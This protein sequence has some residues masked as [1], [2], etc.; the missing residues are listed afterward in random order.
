VAKELEATELIGEYRPTSK[1]AVVKDLYPRL[2]FQ[3]L[4]EDSGA[5]LWQLA[6]ADRILA[7]PAWFE[8]EFVATGLVS[9][10]R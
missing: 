5:T 6:S 7:V 3:P 1:N 9:T 10:A 2:G 8:I 4:R